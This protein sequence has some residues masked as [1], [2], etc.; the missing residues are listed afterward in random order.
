M[1]LD[2]DE[3]A[4]AQK[5]VRACLL[6]HTFLACDNKHKKGNK[7]SNVLSRMCERRACQLGATRRYAAGA[8]RKPRPS[9]RRSSIDLA[10]LTVFPR[11][12]GS[13]GSTLQGPGTMLCWR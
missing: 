8:Q 6:W 1:R 4:A 5:R 12:R 7:L 11:A 13:C 3:A 9:A 2:L 10:R